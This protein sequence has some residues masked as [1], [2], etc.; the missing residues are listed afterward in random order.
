M[1]PAIPIAVNL[2]KRVLWESCVFNGISEPFA[3]F[4]HALRATL[5]P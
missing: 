4:R 5:N 3:S 1:T 2:A